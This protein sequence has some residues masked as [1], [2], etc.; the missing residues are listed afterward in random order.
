MKKLF[1]LAVLFPII[2]FAQLT[3][4]TYKDGEQVLKGFAG[5]PKKP[6]S[7]KPGILILPAWMGIDEHSKEVAQ[8]LNNQGYYSFIADIYGEG[9]YPT[10]TKEAGQLAGYYKNNV[11]DYQRRIQLA[12]D[13]LIASG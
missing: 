11:T 7:N 9:N 6:L 8:N 4:K 5:V 13:Q 12:L 3:S 10:T 1:V 2:S